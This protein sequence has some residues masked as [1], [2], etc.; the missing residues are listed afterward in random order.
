MRNKINFMVQKKCI[1]YKKY[2][3]TYSHNKVW[4]PIQKK[5]QIINDQQ[6]TQCEKMKS[7]EQSKQQ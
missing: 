5:K 6:S 2:K 1:L 7:R 3:S 4:D